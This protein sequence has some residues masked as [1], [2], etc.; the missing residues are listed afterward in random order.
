MA[1]KE[2]ETKIMKITRKNPG[3][4]PITI[5]LDSEDELRL[6]TL[7]V[8]YNATVAAALQNGYTKVEK[9]EATE[10]AAF[11]RDIFYGLEEVTK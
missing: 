6:L 7:V 2:K 1:T 9:S 8:G 3:F 5:V 10:I 4:E 11:L